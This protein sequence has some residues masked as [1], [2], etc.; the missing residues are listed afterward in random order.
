MKPA[1]EKT[2][3]VYERPAK[4]AS[5]LKIAVAA[6]VAIVLVLIAVLFLMHALPLE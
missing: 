3:G 5:G 1:P 6:I 4:K 2:F